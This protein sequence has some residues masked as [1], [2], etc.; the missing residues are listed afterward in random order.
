MLSGLFMLTITMDHPRHSR[1]RYQATNLDTGW[2]RLLIHFDTTFYL[3]SINTKSG[4]QGQEN[5]EAS[6]YQRGYPLKLPEALRHLYG[7][8]DE[9]V[10]AG[11]GVRAE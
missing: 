5:R 7:G 9:C 11:A 3:L 1:S 4:M 2:Y 10:G 6:N 8:Q